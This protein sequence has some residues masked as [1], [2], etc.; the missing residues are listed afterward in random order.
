MKYTSEELIIQIQN[1]NQ[2]AFTYLYDNYSKALFGVIY[3]IASS[4]ELA[5][6]ILQQAFLK[7]WE[8]FGSYNESKGRLYTWMVNICR[9]LAIDSTRSKQEK[10]K[11]KNHSASDSIKVFNKLVS[12]DKSHD[13]I[14]F[15]KLL[16]QLKTEEKEL[17]NLAYFNG[18]TQIEIS[19]HLAIPLG[20]VKTKMRLTLLKLR[21]VANGEFNMAA[22]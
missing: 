14:G 10:N 19:K 9:N 7:I 13:F 5:E 3:N 8:S 6:D 16:N 4:Q 12:E 22:L 20:S 2:K 15:E 1:G 11:N 17:I 18:Y 21:V